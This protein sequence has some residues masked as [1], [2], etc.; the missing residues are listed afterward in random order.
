MTLLPLRLE[1]WAVGSQAKGKL[2]EN[3]CRVLLRQQSR[4]QAGERAH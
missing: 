1:H 4:K 3:F 2:S